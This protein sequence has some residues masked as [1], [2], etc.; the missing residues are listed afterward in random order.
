MYFMS[1]LKQ[2][3]L[4]RQ[5]LKLPKGKA[6]AQAAHAAVEAVL[7][8]DSNTVSEWRR[9]GMAKIA[10]KVKDEKELVKYFQ[11]AKDDGLAVSLITDAMKCVADNGELVFT[12]NKRNFK[13]DFEAVAALDFDVKSISEL[14]RDK[15]FQRNKHIHNSWLIT[16]KKVKV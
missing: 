10:L 1:E 7:R 6:C 3:I 16:R 14:T 2:V 11:M 15:D 12:N 8:S 13:M 9:S 5:D 4:V